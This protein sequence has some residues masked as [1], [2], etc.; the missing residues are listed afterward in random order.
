MIRS[1]T[2]AIVEFSAILFV[3]A[4]AV[5]F[6]QR[7]RGRRPPGARRLSPWR[8]P[9][10]GPGITDAVNP[11]PLRLDLVTT[12]EQ[13]WITF[14]QIEQ[15]AFVSDAPAAFAKGVGEAQVERNFTQT[16]PVSIQARRLR[17]QPELDRFLGLKA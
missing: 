13:G 14:D 17:H 6:G 9:L 4:D 8:D 12:H 5:A 2:A 11:D 3:P 7:D 16:D 1:V 15:Q 10:L